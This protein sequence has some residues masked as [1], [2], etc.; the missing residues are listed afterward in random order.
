MLPS[1]TVG[2]ASELQYLPSL[3]VTTAEQVT[4]HFRLRVARRS[5]LRKR[6][7]G[8]AA[9]PDARSTRAALGELPQS[10]TAAV[11]A[12]DRAHANPARCRP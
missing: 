1:G 4:H 12:D 6:W 3:D 11:A 5:A 2:P 8:P 10:I 9:G 7:L